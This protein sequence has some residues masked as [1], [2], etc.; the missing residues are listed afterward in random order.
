MSICHTSYT[1]TRHLKYIHTHGGG[2]C[3]GCLARTR[4]SWES[5]AAE[6]AKR[7]ADADAAAEAVFVKAQEAKAAARMEAPI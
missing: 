3:R 4:S 1:I 5:A 2:R 6:T 7:K